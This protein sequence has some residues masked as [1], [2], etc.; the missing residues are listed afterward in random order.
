MIQ[1]I[2]H[3]VVLGWG[4]FFRWVCGKNYVFF[5][6]TMKSREKWMSPAVISP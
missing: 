1:Y 4:G 6:G 3:K 2:L 5:L